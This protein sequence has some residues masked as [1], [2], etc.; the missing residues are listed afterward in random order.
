MEC[1]RPARTHLSYVMTRLSNVT[2]TTVGAEMERDLPHFPYY[3]S[4]C[5][6][7]NY[8][9]SVLLMSRSLFNGNGFTDRRPGDNIMVSM[10]FKD[11][12]RI[13]KY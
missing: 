7:L 4:G 13:L 5:K 10:C 9:P 11:P 12:A 1:S 2:P 6:I 3:Y 8:C